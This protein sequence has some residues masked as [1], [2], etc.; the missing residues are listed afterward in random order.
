M[1]K[2]I[3][4]RAA[5][6]LACISLSPMLG[7]ACSSSPP[8]LATGDEGNDASAGPDTSSI[9]KSDTG[10]TGDTGSA[11]E[12]GSSDGGQPGDGTLGSQDTGPVQGVDSAVP[13][14][15][16]LFL[17][18]NEFPDQN[19]IDSAQPCSFLVCDTCCASDGTCVLIP[20]NT[21]CGSAGVNCVD[22]TA[23]GETCGPSNSCQ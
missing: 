11:G 20:S 12:T 7:V 5:T 13:D 10:A 21:Q 8:P 15:P 17:D 19:S 3:L 14:A 22:C 4:I 23:S 9:V 6:A 2:K 18:G 1:N 16:I